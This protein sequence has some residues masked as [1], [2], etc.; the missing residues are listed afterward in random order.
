M[1]AENKVVE[2]DVV[3]IDVDNNQIII[4]ILNDD[5]DLSDFEVK[6]IIIGASLDRDLPEKVLF[7]S[8]DFVK[9]AEI[10]RK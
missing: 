6:K 4:N 8:I 10:I 9:N 5:Y 1:K 2:I 3:E 7:A